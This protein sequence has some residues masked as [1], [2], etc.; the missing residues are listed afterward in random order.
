MGD[1]WA[2]ELARILESWQGG[3]ITRYPHE[4]LEDFARL[5]ELWGGSHDDEHSGRAAMGRGH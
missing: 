2:N 5:V 1:N 3:S 4:A